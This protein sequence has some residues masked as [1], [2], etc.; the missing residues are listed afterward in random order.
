[1]QLKP[2]LNLSTWTHSDSN[3]PKPTV[4]ALS[5]VDIAL[6]FVAPDY[7]CCLY[8]TVVVRKFVDYIEPEEGKPRKKP[9]RAADQ[10]RAVALFAHSR[11]LSVMTT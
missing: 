7:S 11:V 10:V 5:L 4:C 8:Y 9:V 1:V 3:L 6:A 2:I